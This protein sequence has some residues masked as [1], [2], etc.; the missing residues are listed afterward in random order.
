MAKLTAKKDT[1][2]VKLTRTRTPL[3]HSSETQEVAITS[4]G[5][6]LWRFKG[7]TLK[8]RPVQ[9][10]WTNKKTITTD[11]PSIKKELRSWRGKGFRTVK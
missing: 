7:V 9:V 11:E 2:L 1:V 5:R 10:S 3:G 6:V 8:K 4:S